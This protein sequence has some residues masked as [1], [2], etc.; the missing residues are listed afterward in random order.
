MKQT[1]LY[2]IAVLSLGAALQSFV[3]AGLLLLG[4]QPITSSQQIGNSAV[5]MGI[6][7]ILMI[8]YVKVYRAK[9]ERCHWCLADEDSNLWESS[10]GEAF[11]FGNEDPSYSG[12]DFCP[13]CG[14]KIEM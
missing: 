1:I 8:I 13:Y 11:Y 7:S 12:F 4:I 9:T 14:R 2:S 6:Y 5:F 10:C 3:T